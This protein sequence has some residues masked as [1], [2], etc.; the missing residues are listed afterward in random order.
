MDSCLAAFALYCVMRSSQPT[1]VTQVSIQA[2][3]ACAGTAD[4]TMMAQILGIDS[5]GQ[6]ERGDLIDFGAQL[7]R[8]LV[9][10]DGMQVH[11][12]EDALVVVLDAD[13]VLE[14]AQIIS[15]VQISGGL[16]AGEDSCF[17]GRWQN[18]E[19]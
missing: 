16:H 13:P 19:G 10:R 12:A 9:R 1:G 4:C 7:R 14:R 15:D 18:D 2:S 5:G 17:H 8:I 3:S 6:I 11:D